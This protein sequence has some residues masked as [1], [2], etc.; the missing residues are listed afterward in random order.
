MEST[1]ELLSENTFETFTIEMSQKQTTRRKDKNNNVTIFEQVVMFSRAFKVSIDDVMRENGNDYILGTGKR[2]MDE[3]VDMRE[4]ANKHKAGFKKFKSTTPV[5]VRVYGNDFL[6][7]SSVL[8]KK[9]GEKLYYSANKRLQ[10]QC[11]SRM[12][13]GLCLERNE[14]L[15]EKRAALR[16][17]QQNENLRGELQAITEEK[18]LLKAEMKAIG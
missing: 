7:D 9:I 10:L 3:Y 14:K 18:R 13:F 6:F 2:T 11:G 16:L 1:I 4:V 15:N 5:S 8:E 17:K 12:Y